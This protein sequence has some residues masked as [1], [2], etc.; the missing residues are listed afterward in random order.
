MDDLLSKC[1]FPDLNL[2]YA[3][4]LRQA[5]TLILE[6][7]TPIGIIAA[8]SILR[9]SPDPTSDLDLYVIHT[10]PFRQRLQRF[11]NGVPAEIFV[12]PP[13]Q[14]ERYFAEEQA[15]G[16]PITA[17][18]LATGFVI[19]ATDPLVEQLRSR[20]HQL[21]T[22]PPTWSETQLTW[23]RYLA[24]NL[25]EDGLDMAGRDPASAQV[26]LSRAVIAML[27]YFFRSHGM[28]LPRSKE[29]LDRLAQADPALGQAAR[30]FFTSGDFSERLRLAEQIA[31]VTVGVHGF[32]E[33]D[34]A[35]E[36]V[37]PA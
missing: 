23:V 1:S 10:A 28:F 29:L 21:L 26:F 13:A 33:W 4:A 11:F 36:E 14:V 17:H 16:R 30:R 27:E 12:N 15:D 19:L 25:Y 32:F 20:A 8:G 31:D 24:G 35:P 3:Q 7:Y 37:K 6:Q 18:M 22:Q 5:V 34:S 9:G 2:P